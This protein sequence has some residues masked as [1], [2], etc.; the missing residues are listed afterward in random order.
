MLTATIV[1]VCN[2]LNS[3][4]VTVT[5]TVITHTNPITSNLI[6]VNHISSHRTQTAAAWCCWS[7][8]RVQ[9]RTV[10]KIELRHSVFSCSFLSWHALKEHKA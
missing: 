2:N 6:N 1:A 9:W 5:V 8:W 10:D 7:P 3:R 4:T